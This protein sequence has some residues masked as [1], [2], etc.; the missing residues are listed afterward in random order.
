MQ[1]ILI[2]KSHNIFQPII[3]WDEG[4]FDTRVGKERVTTDIMQW[5]M[6]LLCQWS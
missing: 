6:T 3:T 1:Y 2:Y 5:T 4:Y